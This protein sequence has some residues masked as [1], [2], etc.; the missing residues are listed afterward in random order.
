MKN[1][2]LK[3]KTNEI[4]LKIK[5]GPVPKALIMKPETA[6]PINL[7]ELKLTAL[8]LMAFAISSGGSI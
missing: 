7:A 4:E 1:S 6:G 5:D 8:K 3:I 2:A